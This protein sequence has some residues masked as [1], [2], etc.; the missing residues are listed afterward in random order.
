MAEFPDGELKKR[1][2]CIKL[3]SYSKSL[4]RL[5]TTFLIGSDEICSGK[6]SCCIRKIGRDLREF[7]EKYVMQPK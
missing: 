5:S 4:L 2:R 6:S 1:T 3:F 7:T